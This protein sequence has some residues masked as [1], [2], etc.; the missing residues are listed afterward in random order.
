MAMPGGPHNAE[1]VPE[2]APARGYLGYLEI[3]RLLPDALLDMMRR[4]L[5]EWLEDWL[6]LLCLLVLSRTNVICCCSECLC[7][8]LRDSLDRFM[9]WGSRAARQLPFRLPWM[10]RVSVVIVEKREGEDIGMLL[11]H[12]ASSMVNQAVEV[13]QVTADGPLEGVVDV[14]DHIESVDGVRT[15]MCSHAKHLL[16]KTGMHTCVLLRRPTPGELACD[17]WATRVLLLLA[18]LIG[19]HVL[20]LRRKAYDLLVSAGYISLALPGGQERGWD[21]HLLIASIGSSTRPHFQQAQALTIG[22][23]AHLLRYDES[24]AP[25]HVCSPQY[26]STEV[27]GRGQAQDTLRR[28]VRRW[29]R[30]VSDVAGATILAV[31]TAPR[32]LLRWTRAVLWQDDA[33]A[34]LGTAT[35][36]G[37]RHISPW[38]QPAT[39]RVN[40]TKGWWC[41]QQRLMAV[42]ADVLRS[43]PVLPDF[44]LLVD[45]DTYV[46][47]LSL[48]RF[49][50]AHNPSRPLYAGDQRQKQYAFVFGGG[51]HLLSRA[52]LAA[53]RPRIN[54]CLHWGREFWCEWHSDWILPAC[55]KELGIMQPD[56]ITDGWPLFSQ[57]CGTTLF[58]ARR[59]RRNGTA[60]AV[61]AAPVITARR[62]PQ[63]CDRKFAHYF[64]A[65]ARGSGEALLRQPCEPPQLYYRPTM[66]S[67]ATEPAHQ[68][69]SCH[70]IKSAA[71]MREL[72]RE[73]C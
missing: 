49:I 7:D 26:T 34:T 23:G 48:R 66:D 60:A 57:D 64:R 2:R 30:S 52:V 15:Q 42:L 19:C 40:A 51:G 28:T 62:R 17:Q 53:L 58:H 68:L 47:V 72:H 1:W 32:D 59:R 31:L 73:A 5:S 11:A 54:E 14:K 61:Y 22:C 43:A 41:A 20:N 44:L 16:S 69:V 4:W 46:N 71:K 33:A 67:N 18:G 36:T 13:W 9:L 27:F 39:V 29:M 38:D 6:V 25:C 37:P 35:Q 65:R 55:L 8:H 45:D 10:R 50:H 3:D 63:S 21:E 56:D 12:S 24:V 70:F